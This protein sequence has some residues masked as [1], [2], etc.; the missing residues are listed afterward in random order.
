MN[1]NVRPTEV[2]KPK[3]PEPPADNSVRKAA[4]NVADHLRQVPGRVQDAAAGVKDKAGEI[5]GAAWEKAAKPVEKAA[6]V[7]LA[8]GVAV[9]GNFIN[10]A[11]LE[12]ALQKKVDPTEHTV[13][14]AKDPRSEAIEQ[15]AKAADA[16]KDV[17]EEVAEKRKRK[18]D[19]DDDKNREQRRHPEG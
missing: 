18:E 1:D 4:S 9:G 11:K 6:R 12:A 15:R 14:A 17:F 8:V 3:P 10:E 16:L 13:R 2:P 7:G 19:D 5:A